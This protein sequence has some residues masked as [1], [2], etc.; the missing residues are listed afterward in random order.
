MIQFTKEKLLEYLILFGISLTALALL[1][2]PLV[3]TAFFKSEFQLLDKP[4]I[5]AVIISLYLCAIP[6]MWALINLHA[7]AKMVAKGTPFTLKSVRALK[8]ISLSIF[9]E[10]FLVFGVAYYLKHSFEF[11]KHA[12]LIA[13]LSIFTF[14]C[15]VIGLL[16]YLLSHL[17][18]KARQ[19]KEDN[20][21]TI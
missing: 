13:P 17:F 2:I 9:S 11:F 8:A 4:V 14:L 18:D 16:C 5:S 1:G 12:L 19:L 21:L 7:L 20:D 6:Y 10:I 3:V 15:L